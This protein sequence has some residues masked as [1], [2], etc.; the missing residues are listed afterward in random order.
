M[1]VLGSLASLL[2]RQTSCREAVST[3]RLYKEH[4]FPKRQGLPGHGRM[5]EDLAIAIATE[6]LGVI[7]P[8]PD[9]GLDES[10]LVVKLLLEVLLELAVAS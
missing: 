6:S 9:S 4:V 3:S 7:R 2:T 1:V 8:L 5:M 10:G